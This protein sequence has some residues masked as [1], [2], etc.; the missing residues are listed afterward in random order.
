VEAGSSNLLTPTT[1]PLV[2][3][4]REQ[5]GPGFRRIGVPWEPSWEPFGGVSA[6]R[7]EAR[8]AANADDPLARRGFD[9][10]ER[11]H[12]ARHRCDGRTVDRLGRRRCRAERRA[13]AKEDHRP[14]PQGG[15]R[16]VA[17]DPPRACACD[18][19]SSGTSSPPTGSAV[20]S[21]INSPSPRSRGGSAG[22]RCPA[23]RVASR[24]RGRA[25]RT[26]TDVGRDVGVGD[27][28]PSAIRPRAPR[29]GAP[30]LDRRAGTR[31]GRCA[32]LPRPRIDPPTGLATRRGAWRRWCRSFHPP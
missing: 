27:R 23:A 22:R 28:A 18:R 24:R 15:C 21:S 32:A 2:T 20:A 25:A 6:D 31:R 19:A 16:E 13:P 7:L 17:R 14:D 4:L 5:P 9:L 12:A 30:S 8:H 11:R 1:K 3:G 29:R 10:P 26:T